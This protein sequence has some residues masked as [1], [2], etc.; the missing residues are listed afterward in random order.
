MKTTEDRRDRVNG[1]HGWRGR[2]NSTPARGDRTNAAESRHDC[3]RTVPS[4][5]DCLSTVPSRHGGISTADDRDGGSDTAHGR[6]RHAAQ[7]RT[8]LVLRPVTAWRTCR[9]TT[10]RPSDEAPAR[11]DHPAAPARSRAV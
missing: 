10:R 2:L 6:R 5:H 11:P 7:A 1:A 9:A 3:L 8:G 4:R